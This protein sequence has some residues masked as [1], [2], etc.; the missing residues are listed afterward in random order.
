MM[1]RNRVLILGVV[2]AAVVA[3]ELIAPAASPSRSVAAGEVTVV[4][5]VEAPTTM[6]GLSVVHPLE[7]QV[8]ERL[9]VQALTTSAAQAETESSEERFD[10]DDVVDA[11]IVSLMLAENREFH[12][13]AVDL[14]SSLGEE[15]PD[16]GGS[17]RRALAEAMLSRL[18]GWQFAPRVRGAL[19]ALLGAWGWQT[20][21]LE[22]LPRSGE[23]WRS[24]M[25][26]LSWALDKGSSPWGQSGLPL[27]VNELTEVL[28][29]GGEMGDLSVLPIVY[30][31]RPDAEL[32]TELLPRVTTV[33]TDFEGLADRTVALLAL[34]T[35]VDA[36]ASTLGTLRE[37]LFS[38]E[39]LGT[40]VRYTVLF[41][42]TKARSRAARRVVQEFVD[43]DQIGDGGM[44]TSLHKAYARAW[45]ADHPDAAAEFDRMAASLLDDETAPMEKVGSLMGLSQ[46]LEL[47]SSQDTER[48]EQLLS[49][50]SRHESHPAVRLSA[51][52]MLSDMQGGSERLVALDHALR[53]DTNA[54]ARLLASRGLGKTPEPLSGEAL[55]LLRRHLPDESN[56]KVIEEIR[57]LLGLD[58]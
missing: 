4:V 50:L 9:A 17:S 43:D 36:D 29:K 10:A 8:P 42:L 5:P 18:E 19:V 32:V 56:E 55:A 27:P 57:Q 51:L 38:P 24:A 53:N 26:G 39:L 46:T 37:L 23:E 48:A 41:V 15:L 31:R 47:L 1:T 2:L 54:T 28:R 7:G 52:G 16:D 13:T 20:E 34:G 21:V 30:S 3:W 33:A 14:L 45:L 44:G 35:S 58:G 6:Q 22:V 11:L 12:A 40:Q 25:A 49:Q